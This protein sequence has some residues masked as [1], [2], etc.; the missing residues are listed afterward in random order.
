MANLKWGPNVKNMSAVSLPPLWKYKPLKYSSL[1]LT[2][3][4]VFE[5]QF[6]TFQDSDFN[7]SRMSNLEE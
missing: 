6:N 1:E 4:C 2:P 3:Y 5:I 7:A